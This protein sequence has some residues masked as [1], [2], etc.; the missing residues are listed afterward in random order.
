MLLSPRNEQMLANK[1]EN[2]DFFYR[3]GWDSTKIV[4][5]THMLISFYT[6]NGTVLPLRQGSRS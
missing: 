3:H 5:F 2:W 1:F 4:T 6:M